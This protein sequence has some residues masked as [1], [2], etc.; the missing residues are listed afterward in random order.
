[1]SAAVDRAAATMRE[2]VVDGGGIKKGSVKIDTIKVTFR[3]ENGMTGVSHIHYR[4]DN[5]RPE[6]FTPAPVSDGIDALAK[7][8]EKELLKLRRADR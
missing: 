5:E 7:I 8:V 4:P 3:L 1:M 2:F 6:L